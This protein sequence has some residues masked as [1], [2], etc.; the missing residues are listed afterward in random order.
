[1]PIE[2]FLAIFAGAVL[3]LVGPLLWERITDGSAI[4]ALAR[5]VCPA[6]G[7]AIGIQAAEQAAE[8]VTQKNS[9][10][11]MIRGGYTPAAFHQ[12]WDVTCPSC[13]ASLVFHV[14]KRRVSVRRKSA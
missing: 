4:G 12:S 3:V 9:G 10:I 8:L 11:A 1:V 6:C 13:S 5:L 7:K 14:G 2:A